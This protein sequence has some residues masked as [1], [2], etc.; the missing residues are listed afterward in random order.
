MIVMTS[1]HGTQLRDHG[2]FG[3]G[4][5]EMHPF[6]TRI[7]LY[8]R[9]PEGPKETTIHP[10]VQ[11]HDLLPTILRLLDVPYANV[12]GEDAWT[13]VSGERD[14]LRDHIVSGWAS[15]VTGNAGGRAAVRDDNWNYV[16]TIHEEDHEPELYDLHADPGEDH[17]VHDAHPEVVALQRRR[18]EAVIGQRLPAK[19][20][21]VCDPSSPPLRRYLESRADKKQG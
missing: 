7:P 21:E 5:A 4:A 11:S 10:F 19:L 12:D 6:N 8:I 15:F 3:K 16:T 9:H 20:N 18:L 14:K 1:D 17:N 2:H 13:L